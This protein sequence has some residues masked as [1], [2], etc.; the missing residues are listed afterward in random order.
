MPLSPSE[1]ILARLVSFDT[2]S[3][4][5][6]L[7]LIDYI[8]DYLE[9][10]GVKSRK[11]FDETGEKAN[12]WATIGPQKDGG[13]VLSGHTDVVPVDGQDWTSDPFELTERD[14]RLF[15]RGACDM[16]GFVAAC[17]A[18][19]PHF[20]KRNL[21]RPIHLAFSYDEEIGCIGVKGLLEWL[22]DAPY[23]PRYCIV[24]E[25][26]LMGVVVGHKGKRSMQITVTGRTC[27]SSL[28]PQGVNAVDYA[29]LLTV[30]MREIGQRLA[31]NGSRDPEYDVIHTTAH[32]GVISGG[33]ALNIVPDQ[34]V[35]MCEFRALPGEDVDALVAELHAYAHD[36]LEPEMKAIAPEAGI[37]IELTSE[38]P[39]LETAPDAEI[40]TLAKRLSET[41]THSKVAFG[42]EAGRF[43]DMLGLET[44]VCGPGSIAMAHKADE[45]IERDQ[46]ARCDR[47]LERL[48]DWAE[49]GA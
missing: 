18:A 34:C 6:N 17:L 14:G 10:L 37:V 20:Q 31:R 38:I 3:R 1:E 28:A 15:G 48:A 36:V 2:T 5:T 21:A 46:M 41:N 8:A 45:Y 40:V 11:V 49:S 30:K 23:R 24:G 43:H 13:I 9:G 26:T 27:H 33:T 39:G 32:T 4:N 42:T 29:A 35:M 7:P 25:P 19:V 16:K 22:K 47:F 12:L 44:V